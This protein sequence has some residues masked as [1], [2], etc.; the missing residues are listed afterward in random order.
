MKVTK[1]VKSMQMFHQPVDSAVQGD[2]L[3][4]CV[5]Q[6]DA[7]SL[8]RGIVCSPG[9]ASTIFAAV[10][11]VQPIRFY[12]GEISSKSKF[13]ISMGHETVMARLTF[14]GN[15]VESPSSPGKFKYDDEYEYQ[16]CLIRPTDETPAPKSQYAL[17]EFERPVTVIPNS[18][19]LGS[20]LDT[21]IQSN[22]CRL[23]FHGS[24]L[25]FFTDPK[26]SEKNLPQ[27]RLFKNKRKE[28]VVERAQNEYEVI[29]RSLFKK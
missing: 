23:S 15:D 10:I 4:I 24:L 11:A 16:K 21:D 14:F 6:F 20:K 22:V 19:V 18:L 17:L 28:G 25:D 13:H 29:A 3:G 12:K 2:R 5:T 9:A 27:L 1:K 8:E 7:K 26:Y